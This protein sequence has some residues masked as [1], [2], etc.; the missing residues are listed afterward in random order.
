MNKFPHLY[1]QKTTQGSD[2]YFANVRIFTHLFANLL[3]YFIY[4]RQE[5][6]CIMKIGVF[7]S[8]SDNLEPVYYNETERLGEW[9]GRNGHSI[10]YGGTAQGLMECLAK[11][12]KNAGGC[13]IGI[14]PQM[15]YDNGLASR[16]ADQLII[17]AD[18]VERKNRMMETADV[19]V[20][21]PG[22]FGTW[23]EIFHVV[24]C[25][26]IGC[27]LKRVILFNQN[28]FYDHLIAQME[29]AFAERFTPNIYRKRITPVNDVFEC[30]YE[31]EKEL[32]V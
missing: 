7:C 11:S 17:T 19:F 12:V 6:D 32:D 25:G 5:T 18:M 21:L 24:A 27:H 3:K 31:L 15:M 13:V 26:Q 23:D 30:F 14:L 9:I 16:T 22:G 29:Q 4:L 28:G 1:A 2:F 8:A 20:A 10:V